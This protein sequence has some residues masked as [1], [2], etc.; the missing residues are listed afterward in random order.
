[1]RELFA[2][3]PGR[4]EAFS[5]GLGGLFLD[6]S[7]NRITAETMTLLLA[8]AQERGVEGWRRRLFSGDEVNLTEGRRA[9]HVALRNPGDGAF[10]TGGEE[11]MAAVKAAR[12]GIRKVADDI[13]TG[14][15]TGAK[16]EPLEAVV[17]IGIG[18]SHLGPAMAVEA[19]AAYR[20]PGPELHFVAN[21]D[22]ARITGTLEGLDPRTTL[23]IVV[24]KTFTTEE[25]LTNAGT[26]RAWLSEAL[27]EAAV[28]THF[29]AVTA[30]VDAA[31]AFGIAAAN[32]LELWDWVGG[33]F[34]LCSAVGLPIAIALGM[35]RFEDL[36]AGA[37]HM[38]R[39]FAEAPLEANMPVILALIGLWNI[40][41]LGARALCVLPYDDGLRRLPAYLQQLEMESNG[42]SVTLDGGPVEAATAPVIFGAAGTEGQHAF[43]QALHQGT[44][45]I[46]CDFIAPMQSHHP[47]GDH[48]QR[49]LANFLAQ[50]EA[51]MMGRT[52]DQAKAAMKAQG[53]TGAKA[54]S[55]LPHRVFEGNR[56]SNAILLDRVDP[57]TLGQLI[58]LYEHKVFV[59]GVIWG[60]NPSDQWGVG[61][62]KER[63][64]VILG[65]LEPGAP[66]KDHDS[67]TRGL[68]GRIKAQK[69]KAQGAKTS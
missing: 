2:E 43:Y 57:F 39:H 7:K 53:V 59:Q 47:T 64:A 15:W 34:S 37:H 17:I 18:G 29:I 12:D 19:L 28:A 56:P 63:A 4:F 61:L 51:L 50:S 9:L 65:E 67:S 24:S 38:D 32:T 60:I 13:H 41:F 36:L 25:T 30:D 46:A 16:G 69:T 48:H 49:L 5:L 8:L 52:E 21:I 55:Q 3:D 1:M 26:A 14:A 33:R 35:D 11:V 42:K 44:E 66:A 54:K 68:I 62:G 40:D 20:R 58:A 27:G 45:L 10:S 6:Y 22:G 31:A 23:F